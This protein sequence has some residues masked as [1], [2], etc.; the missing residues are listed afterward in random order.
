VRSRWRSP[1]RAGRSARRRGG[2]EGGRRRRDRDA[3]DLPRALGAC[4]QREHAGVA[5]GTRWRARGADEPLDALREDER[6]RRRTV[7][8]SGVRRAAARPR[9]AR[10][11]RSAEPAGAERLPVAEPVHGAE[12]EERP[13]D[14]AFAEEDERGGLGGDAGEDPARPPVERGQ[15]L[16]GLA[17]QAEPPGSQRPLGGGDLLDRAAAALVAGH[18]YVPL[19]S[20]TRVV[21]EALLEEPLRV[22]LPAGHPLAQRR[23]VRLA[24]LA[25]ETWIRSTPRSSCH[26]F[27]ERACRA[28]GFE[29]RIRFEFDDYAAMQNLVASGAG[30]ALA[31]DPGPHPPEPGRGRAADRLRPEAPGSRGVSR[32]RGRAVRDPGHARRPAGDGRRTRAAFPA[33]AGAS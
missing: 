12:A 22:V 27:T 20:D 30:V 32:R 15:V 4:F 24:D 18:D 23:A 29:P 28:A 10:A 3:L 1:G 31:P 8:G 33:V 7:R 2:A 14:R 5:R 26:P 25:G 21:Y 6:R 9:S 13:R 11:R 17:R 19:P 16:L